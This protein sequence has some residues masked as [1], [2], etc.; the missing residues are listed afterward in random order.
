MAT[1]LFIYFREESLEPALSMREALQQHTTEHRFRG[2]LVFVCVLRQ[3]DCEHGHR[4]TYLL[5]ELEVVV[6]LCACIFG[7]LEA[8]GSASYARYSCPVMSSRSLGVLRFSGC[9]D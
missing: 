2:S 8:L 7:T 4:D 3:L 9:Y 6:G 5:L 1:L